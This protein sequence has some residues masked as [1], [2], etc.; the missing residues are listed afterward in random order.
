MNR[1]LSLTVVIVL[2]VTF[3]I[4]VSALV[5]HFHDAAK[6]AVAGADNTCPTD[7]HLMHDGMCHYQGY[8]YQ[9]LLSLDKFKIPS[10]AERRMLGGKCPSDAVGCVD[11]YIPIIGFFEGQPAQRRRMD[12]Q[13]KPGTQITTATSTSCPDGMIASGNNCQYLGSAEFYVDWDRYE[14]ES[15]AWD[16]VNKNNKTYAGVAQDSSKKW[17]VIKLP[18]D[19]AGF[20][21]FSEKIT[22]T[23][24]TYTKTAT[25]L[26][27]FDLFCQKYGNP[28]DFCNSVTRQTNQKPTFIPL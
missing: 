25:Y 21:G 13:V 9:P 15:Q 17:R 28:P 27:F 19:S 14:S 23:N 3:A 18:N 20:T 16:R 24:P 26:L 11:E 5:L 4:A 22:V 6:A 8:K 10:A 1:W 2:A 7:F 12:L